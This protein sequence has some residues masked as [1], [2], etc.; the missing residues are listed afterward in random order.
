MAAFGLRRVQ[1]LFSGSRDL[2][3]IVRRDPEHLPERLALFA[4][5]RLGEPS[6][7]WARDAL[8][9]GTDPGVVATRLRHQSGRVARIDGAISGT[10]FFLAL[11]PGYLGYLWQEAMMVL[12]TAALYGHDPGAL[13]TGAEMLTLRGIHPTVEAA[14][15]AIKQVD[16]TPLPVKPEHRRPVRYWV[17]SIRMILVFGGFLSPPSSREMDRPHA[18]LLAAVGLIVGAAVWVFTW[19][20]PVTF[21]VFMAWACERDARG[22]GWRALAF[23]GGE[24]ATTEGAIAAA[25]LR[26]DEGHR[27]RQ[28]VG[29]GTLALSVALPIAFIAIAIRYRHTRGPFHPVS[30]AGALVALSLV[31]A[32]TV[33]VNRR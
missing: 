22:M 17:R 33:A 31:I 26:R 28:L 8:A 24:A 18:K 11:V 32:I 4:V 7:V 6:H 16:A 20:F 9:D 30:I 19:I 25:R 1:V 13:R 12:R 2:A 10:P 3:A 29:A 21:M 5:H 23:Y 15:A 14:H 27:W